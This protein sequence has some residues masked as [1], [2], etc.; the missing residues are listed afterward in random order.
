MRRALLLWTLVVLLIA[1]AYA[2]SVGPVNPDN[3]TSDPSIG[4]NAWSRPDQ[5]LTS[6]NLYGTVGLGF[7][8]GQSSEILLVTFSFNATGPIPTGATIDG[9]LIEVEQKASVA[10]T[11]SV[12]YSYLDSDG[13]YPP[14][15][16]I[17][18]GGDISTTEG[19]MSCGGSTNL[20]GQSFTASGLNTAL[21]YYYA[22][23]NVGSQGVTVSV[24]HVR[25]TAY[26]TTATGSKKRIIGSAVN[27]ARV[28]P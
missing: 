20:W 22:A 15:G 1:L 23:S 21:Y 28:W 14:D 9:I 3:A 25:A 27:I 7:D 26:Y 6:N 12:T 5:T 16:T 4:D 8:P 24:D 2:A 11:G 18:G 17:Q 13:T 10:S 19:Y